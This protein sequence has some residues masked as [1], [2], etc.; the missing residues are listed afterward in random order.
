MATSDITVPTVSSGCPTL[1]TQQLTC[2]FFHPPMPYCRVRAQYML[3]FFYN[4]LSSL[5]LF[6]NKELTFLL[7]Y[8]STFLSPLIQSIRMPTRSLCR[9]R[10]IRTTMMMKR[11]VKED[12]GPCLPS[13]PC[14]S[15][16]PPTRKWN[17]YKH[18]Q[19]HSAKLYCMNEHRL[20]K[21]NTYLRHSV[22][23]SFLFICGFRAKSFVE[24]G[25]T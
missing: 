18:M 7:H 2:Q 15:C 19:T 10:R 4:P 6:L 20:T 24:N 13:A 12:L 14:S 17:Y 23:I 8:P 9:R 5:T 11:G 3:I 22:N 21:R 1:T 16:P 25:S